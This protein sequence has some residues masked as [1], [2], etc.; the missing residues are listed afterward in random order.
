MKLQVSVIPVLALSLFA[1]SCG[2]SDADFRLPSSSDGAAG[3]GGSGGAPDPVGAG[4]QGGSGMGGSGGSGGMAGSGGSGG[5]PLPKVLPVLVIDTEGKQIVEEVKVDAAMYVVEDHDGTLQGIESQPRTFE[6][7]I[8]IEV[9]GSTSAGFPKKSYGVEIRDGLGQDTDFPLLGLPAESDWVFYGPYTDKTYMRDK[10]AYDLGR[11]MKRYQPRT[12]YAEVILNGAYR[13]VYIVVERIKRGLHRVP[14]AKVAPD[15]ATGDIT[16]GYIFKR[17][18]TSAQNGWYSAAGTPWQF[19]YPKS[20]DILPEQSAYLK[21]YVDAFEAMMTGPQFSDPAQGYTKW[22]DVPSFIDFAIVQELSKNVDGYRK[23]AYFHKDADG[24][25]GKLHMGPLWDF[26]IAFGNADYCAGAQTSGFVYLANSCPDMQQIPAWWKRLM[27]DAAFTKELRCRWNDLRTGAFADGE[28]LAML[29]Q[30]REATKVAE[31]RDH[32]TWKVIGTYV[33]PNPYVGQ[34]YED[35][36]SHLKTWIT[37]RA[38][39]L[40]ANMPGTCP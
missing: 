12:R 28:M 19:H 8:G 25:G 31:V 17:E 22:L 2:G 6:G 30:Y 5:A 33:W 3:M 16:G 9:R 18:A 14:I 15:A 24:D 40:D 39:W 26:N 32:E 21:G 37:A 23:S 29:D 36:L 35:E 7:P 1:G 20:G 4:G 13:G 27:L 38:A 10:L 34:T 11:A